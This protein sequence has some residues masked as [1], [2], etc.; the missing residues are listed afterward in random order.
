MPDTVC[1]TCGYTAECIYDGLV[2]CYVC[3]ES[4][5]KLKSEARAAAKAGGC[6]LCNENRA[7]DYCIDDELFG[8][9]TMVWCVG[10][11][12]GCDC[13]SCY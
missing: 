4:M 2:L 7:C 3:R 5:A 13:P 6:Q 9:I 12:Q 11:H 1:R 8:P 10:S